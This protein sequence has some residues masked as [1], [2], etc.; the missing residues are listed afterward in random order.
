MTNG[1][2]FKYQSSVESIFFFAAGDQGSK[3]IK[4]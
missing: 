2:H 4:Q 1:K 3:I